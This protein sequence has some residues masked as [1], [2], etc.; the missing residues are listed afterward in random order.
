MNRWIMP[1]LA[2]VALAVAGCS[3]SKPVERKE[4]VFSILSAESQASAEADWAPFLAD[5]S[6]ALGRPVK[7]F[8]GSNYTAL[9]EA[10]RFKQT[11]LG[12][13]T[14]QSGLEAVRRG[15]GEVFARSVNPSGIDGYEAVIIVKAGSGLTLDK[16]LACGKTINFGMGDP[17]STSGTLA[18]MTYLF[19]PR[20]IEPASCFKTVRSA[21]HETN[22]FSVSGGLLDA[23]TNNTASMDRLKLLN[24]DVAK[25]TLSNV[26]IVWRSPRIPEDPLVW[27]KDLDPALRAKLADFMFHYG[28]GDTP[29]AARQRKILEQ[30]QTKPFVAAN[31]SHLLPVREMEATGQLLEARNRKD[32]AAEAKAQAALAEIAKERAAAPKS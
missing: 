30:I 19:A 9:I 13:F 16:I 17:K 23:A 27:R 6:K 5:M 4:L 28:V 22:L 21:N 26:E 32:A 20:N 11:D 10:M 25:R 18:P 3:P 24:T 31:D 2:A 1:A 7:A 15:N 14:N 8:Y 12:W 29:E